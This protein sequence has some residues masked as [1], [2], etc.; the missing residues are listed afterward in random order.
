[1]FC[2]SIQV[3]LDSHGTDI[4]KRKGVNL[5]TKVLNIS[6]VYDTPPASKLFIHFILYL[7]S[8]L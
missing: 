7:T 8:A 2:Y 4:T 3:I 1:M 6:C 5:K